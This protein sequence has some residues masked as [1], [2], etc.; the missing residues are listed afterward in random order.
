MR[1][2]NPD[3]NVLQ[4]DYKAQFKLVRNLIK[5]KLRHFYQNKIKKEA[6]NS[7]KSF[8]N[9]FNETWGKTLPAHHSNQIVEITETFNNIF[10]NIGVELAK[11]FDTK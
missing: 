3:N 4:N 10:A 11:T 7:K 9:V 2:H 8:F 6:G 1:L 5:Q